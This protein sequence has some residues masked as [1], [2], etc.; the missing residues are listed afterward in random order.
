MTAIPESAR[1]FLTTGPLGHAATLN[2][3]GTPHVTL[4]WAGFEGDELVMATFY[5]DQRK[6]HNI[7]R[8]PRI[9]V[10]FQARPTIMT[11]K[12]SI[13]TWSCRGMPGSERAGRSS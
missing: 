6:T 9:V 12:E 11:G 7:R 3:D 5:P 1:Q 8:D 10:S 4:T 2:S 13:P